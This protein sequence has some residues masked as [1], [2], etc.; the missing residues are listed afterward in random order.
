MYT[1]SDKQKY[2]RNR[3]LY[4]VVNDD[5]VS[6]FSTFIFRFSR[7]CIKKLGPYLSG[8]WH[9]DLLKN[10]FQF[11][12]KPDDI[13]LKLDVRQA[14]KNKQ[15]LQYLADNNLQDTYAPINGKIFFAKNVLFISVT[16]ALLFFHIRICYYELLNTH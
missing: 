3:K 11:Q 8:T 6:C 9:C 13:R 14:R 7:C 5:S 4:R 1:I 15:Y 2:W 10:L 16:N 12:I